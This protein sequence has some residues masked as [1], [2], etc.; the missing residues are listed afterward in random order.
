VL[1]AAFQQSYAWHDTGLDQP[2]SVNLSARD[3]RDPALVDKLKS[4][5]ATWGTQPEWIQFELTES[6]LMEDPLGALDAIKRIKALGVALFIDDFGIGYSSL[7]YLHKLPVDA[8]KIDQSFVI[9]M[10][11]SAVSAAIVQST[12]ELGHRLNL[13]VVAEGVE[14]E[15]AWT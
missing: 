2:L 4:L 13:E 3:L 9:A 5:F 10:P 15:S 12:I 7:S 6:A 1:E 11:D 8:I 14:T